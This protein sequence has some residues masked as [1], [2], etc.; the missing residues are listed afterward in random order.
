MLIG[1]VAQHSGISARMLRHY[2]RI[3]LVS[4]SGRTSGGYREYSDDDVRRLFHVES[5]RS[6]GL[7]LAQ[8]VDVID[9][10]DFDPAAIVEKVA[11]QT[12]RQIV[13]AQE[14]LVRLEEIAATEPR[15][16]NDVL[17]TISLVRRLETADASARQQLALRTEQIDHRDLPVLIDAMLR[18][19]GEDAAGA[20]QWAIARAG[21][22]AIPTL[23]DALVSDDPDRRRRAFDA[24]T[25]IDSPAARDAVAASATH[26][27]DRIRQ[28]AIIA[29]ARRGDVDSV[30]ALVELIRTGQDDVA[31]AD[32]L[33]DLAHRHALGNVAV[34]ALAQ[35]LAVADA[36][37]RRRLAA[38]LIPF[39]RTLT[40]RVLESLVHDVDRA[41]ALTARSILQRP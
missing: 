31:A 28:R 24:L 7:S 23:M 34:D 12:R 33:A 13:Q 30:A 6:L 22:A 4:P 41:T 11:E 37:A 26:G 15:T 3:G 5:L 2:D 27:D 8:V 39:P 1:D 16:W 36:P 32:A 19:E 29:R 25:K 10:R 14:L 17:R 35:A 20:L 9:D 21:D 40:Q 18:E 38:A